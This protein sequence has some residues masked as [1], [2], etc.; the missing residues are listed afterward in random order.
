M[1]APTTLSDFTLWL[2]ADM[3]IA[4]PI[5]PT[6]ITR[7]QLLRNAIEACKKILLADPG[8]GYWKIKLDEYRKELLCLS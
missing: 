4:N 2:V 6:K 5:D 1:Y 7:E 8:N 3:H